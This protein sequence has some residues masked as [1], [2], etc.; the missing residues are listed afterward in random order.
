MKFPIQK[1]LFF[2]HFLAVL[3]VSGSIGTYFYL[4]AVDNLM[5][6]VQDRLKYSAAL[7][8]RTIDADQMNDIRTEADTDNPEYIEYLLPDTD[9]KGGKM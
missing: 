1:K 4:S 3:L 8:S 2:S 7:I 5:S 9:V 6:N